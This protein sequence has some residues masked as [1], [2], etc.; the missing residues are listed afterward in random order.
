MQ[1]CSNNCWIKSELVKQ[2]NNKWGLIY[3]LVLGGEY[4][5]LAALSNLYLFSAIN[6]NDSPD[7]SGWIRNINKINI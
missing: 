7:L 1:T 4:Q 6:Q 5:Q 2:P 3:P